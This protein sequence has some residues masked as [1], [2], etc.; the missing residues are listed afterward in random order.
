MNSWQTFLEGSLCRFNRGLFAPTACKNPRVSNVQTSSTIHFS[1]F[2]PFPE[3][4]IGN[5]NCA[6]SLEFKET[7]FTRSI[8]MCNLEE[9]TFI[10]TLRYLG[11]TS[12]PG[13]PSTTHSCRIGR[14]SSIL[15]SDFGG[16]WGSMG[17]HVES[18]SS[19]Y[20][21]SSFT[22]ISANA[23]ISQPPFSV[24]IE[25]WQR[26]NMQ[27]RIH[28]RIIVG[29]PERKPLIYKNFEHRKFPNTCLSV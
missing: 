6:L 15:Q 18:S 16:A 13:T 8:T 9:E 23:S 22:A 19:T 20:Y 12:E 7:N 26:T 27:S 2:C 21:Y 4:Y 1:K 29:D 5:I 11:K 3:I 24:T 25:R 28:M 17:E 14:R 10:H